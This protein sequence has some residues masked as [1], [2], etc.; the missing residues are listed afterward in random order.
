VSPW[1]AG[2]SSTSGSSDGAT[3]RRNSVICPYHAWTYKLSGE[4][5][6]ASG[7]TRQKEFDASAWGLVELPAAEWHGLIY[8]DSSGGQAGALA[9][10]LAWLDELVTPY[11][12]E[13]LVIAGRHVY[14]VAANWK[15]LAENYQECYHCPVIHPELSGVSP[16]KSAENYPPQPDLGRRLDG[17]GR[18]HGHDVAGRYQPGPSL[19][20]PWTGRALTLVMGSSSGTSP[21]GRTGVR[22]SPCSVASPRRTHYL[23]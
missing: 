13:R 17:T 19:P 12:P 22:A 9:D 21:I 10:A 8:V 18:R 5:S 14:D 6:F 3:A 11:E 7:L 4:L 23:A 20:R 16:P 2:T 15:I 1:P